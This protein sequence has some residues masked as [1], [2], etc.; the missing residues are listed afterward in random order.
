MIDTRREVKPLIAAL[1]DR[2]VDVGRLFPALPKHLRVTI[3]KPDQMRR[4]LDVF[5][6]VT[7]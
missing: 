6:A 4:F 7:S 1:H 2:G 5:A 3:G